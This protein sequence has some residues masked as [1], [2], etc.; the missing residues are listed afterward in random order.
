MVLSNEARFAERYVTRV[1][2]L[3]VAHWY[4]YSGNA[5]EAMM[6]GKLAVLWLRSNIEICELLGHTPAQCSVILGKYIEQKMVGVA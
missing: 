2:L 5:D 6:Y 4:D 3:L 1:Q